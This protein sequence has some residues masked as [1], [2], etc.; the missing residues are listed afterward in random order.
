MLMMTMMLMVVCCHSVVIVVNSIATGHG[1]LSDDCSHSGL[2]GHRDYQ[3]GNGRRSGNWCNANRGRQGTSGGG[4]WRHQHTVGWNDRRYS[5]QIWW[6]NRNEMWRRYGNHGGGCR[7]ISVGICRNW[8]GRGGH[9]DDSGGRCC[10]HG[11]WRHWVRIV[12]SW[13]PICSRGWRSLL[14]MRRRSQEMVR[15]WWWW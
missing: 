9:G 7:W 15:C 10:P 11:R 14:W 5:G 12:V 8:Y 13:W 6:W 3:G 2:D 1:T 4:T